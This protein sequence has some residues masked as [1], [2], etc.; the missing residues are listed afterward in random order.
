MRFGLHYLLSCAEGQSPAQRYHET[1]EQATRAEDLGF[2]SVWPVEH[3]FNSAVS[4]LPCPTLLLAAIAAR[5]STLRLGTAIVQLPLAHPMRIAEELATLD[6]LSGGR[7]EFGVGRGGNPS[8]FAGFGVP[9]SESRDRMVEALDYIRQ[10]WTAERFSFGGRFFQ[11]NDLALAPK[12]I[13]QPHPPVRVAANSAET[14][15]WAG[16]EG[17]PV[18]FASNVNPLPKLR[19]LIP[20][21][22]RARADAAHPPSSSGDDLTLLMPV[23][24]GDDRRQVE[25]D[26]A[27]SVRRF[28]E[29]AASAFLGLLKKAPEAERPKLQTIAEQLCGMTYHSVNAVTGIFDTPSACV[30]RLHQLRE[31]FNP[32]RVICWFNFGDVIPHDRV[33][34][35]MEL[36][37]SRVLPHFV[38]CP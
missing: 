16:R 7:V 34:Q 24:V 27:P 3:H 20:V 30:E 10:A 32:G 17:Y 6:V 36:F 1:L 19:E 28:A 12:P 26:V 18:F 35:S 4:I 38:G 25:R 15:A 22:R 11:A 13:Q 9:M 29:T 14:A 23:F 37:S 5:T 8:H 21:Y 2:E 31:E 33:L